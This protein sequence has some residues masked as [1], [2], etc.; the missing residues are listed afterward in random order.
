MTPEHEITPERLAKL[1]AY[2]TG[3]DADCAD[4]YDLIAHL[5]AVTR[6]RDQARAIM[7]VAVEER[8]EIA[9]F[10]NLEW[11]S[12]RGGYWLPAE[13]G[14][15]LCLTVPEAVKRASQLADGAA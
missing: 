11:D 10:L 7:E 8:R 13:P 1:R 6:E 3:P 9:A 14:P 5:D 4:C 2:Q 15:I 12:R